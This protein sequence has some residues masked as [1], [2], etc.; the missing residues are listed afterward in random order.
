MM[1]AVEEREAL[2]SL[3][4]GIYSFLSSVFNSAP[5]ER[6]IS[7]LSD[8]DVREM[9]Q[10]LSP[11]SVQ[12]LELPGELKLIRQDFNDL[13]MVPGAKYVTP[14]E[15]VY[16]DERRVDGSWGKRL[17][18]GPSA[19]DVKK[20]YEKAGFKLSGKNIELPDFAGTEI[21]FVATLLREEKKHLENADSEEAQ[22]IKK[23]REEFLKLHLGRWIEPLCD[24]IF[25]KAESDFYKGI[26]LLAK[27]IILQDIDN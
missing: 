22:G 15:S 6:H 11:E 8:N 27:K 5:E 12:Y 14:Y 24:E 21:E 25:K 3:K 4:E 18:M 26:A 17:L 13:F 19:V 7:V 16:V 10:Q 20:F 9:F 2:L 23:L 1:P